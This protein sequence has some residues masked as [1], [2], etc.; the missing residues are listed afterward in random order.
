M[1]ETRLPI[2][3]LCQEQTEWCWAAC[4]SA[5]SQSD[6]RAT[7]SMTQC[8]VV[9]LVENDAACCSHPEQMNVQ[10]NLRDAI[11]AVG[12]SCHVIQAGLLTF[13]DIASQIINRRRPLGAR[14]EDRQNGLAHNVLIVGC[15]NAA[16]S[17]AVCDPWGTIG[18]AVQTW[19]MPFVTFKENYG[20]GAWGRCTDVF[21]VD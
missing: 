7:A 11:E 21:V 20:Q 8:E 6:P 5:I 15:D 13:G 12:L 3:V 1:A 14:I 9:G 19:S 10:A 4:A 17:V 16:H 2:T 18:T